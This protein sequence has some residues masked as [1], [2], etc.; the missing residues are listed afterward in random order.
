METT[1]T[2][3]RTERFAIR[4]SGT[5]LWDDSAHYVAPSDDRAGWSERTVTARS[6]ARVFRTASDAFTWLLAY[7]VEGDVVRVSV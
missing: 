3:T 2:A 7:G 1:N 4:L 5:A 6:R